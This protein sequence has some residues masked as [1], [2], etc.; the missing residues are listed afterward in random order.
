MKVSDLMTTDTLTCAPSTNLAQA[1]ALMWGGDCGVLPVVRDGRLD[2][3]ITDRDICIALG[4]RGTP[5]AAVRVDDVATRDLF[6]CQPQQQIHQALAEMRRGK[7]R[8]LPVVNEAGELQGLLALNDI[9]LA[10]DRKYGVLDCEDVMSTI[11]AVSDHR[12]L[13]AFGGVPEA[14][15]AATG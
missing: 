11:K 14:V 2:G 3:M 4:T 12:R 6:T 1:A 5:A 10:A 8:R 13:A 15:M 9:I 7:V